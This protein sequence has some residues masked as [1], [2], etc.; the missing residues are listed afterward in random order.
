MFLRNPHF[1]YLTNFYCI[2]VARSNLQTHKL[3]GGKKCL[4]V[5]N[6][7]LVLKK[8]IFFYIFLDAFEIETRQILT[9]C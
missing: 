1:V 7:K 8:L 4:N 2:N 3:C 5:S 6:V 9:L